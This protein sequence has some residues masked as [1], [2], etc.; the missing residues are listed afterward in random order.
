MHYL[1]KCQHGSFRYYNTVEASLACTRNEMPMEVARKARVNPL[2]VVAVEAMPSNAVAVSCGEEWSREHV[3]VSPA[4]IVS[5][6]NNCETD[7]Q[8]D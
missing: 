2:H 8:E 3:T 4:E 7:D 1:V 6:I 5:Y